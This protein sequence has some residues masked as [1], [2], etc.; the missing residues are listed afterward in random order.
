LHPHP[1]RAILITTAGVKHPA[2]NTS[3]KTL[4]FFLIMFKFQSSAIDNIV[5]GDNDNVTVTF[6]GG[7]DYIYSCSDVAGFQNDLQNV[8]DENESVGSFVNRAIRAELLQLVTV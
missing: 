8:V 3:L 6:R 2:Q 4:T 7:R 1:I 5:V